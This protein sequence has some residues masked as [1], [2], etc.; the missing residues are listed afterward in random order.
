MTPKNWIKVFL[1][2]VI[3]FLALIF[4]R[5]VIAEGWWEAD[6]KSG[7]G[8]VEFSFH[9]PVPSEE[10]TEITGNIYDLNGI[11]QDPMD[12]KMEDGD[13]IICNTENQYPPIR[14]K[15]YNGSIITNR[16]SAFI[17]P[18]LMDCGLRKEYF[19]YIER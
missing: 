16:Y 13:W 6:S 17:R 15:I 5:N 2:L 8:W 4:V 3:I 12:C 9:S 1:I 14:T 10:I 11:L 19:P 18:T 7:C